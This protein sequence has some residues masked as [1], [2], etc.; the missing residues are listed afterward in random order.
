MLGLRLSEGI[1]YDFFSGSC[2]DRIKE[3]APLLSNA[4]LVTLNDTGIS[5]TTHGFLLSNMVIAAL[6]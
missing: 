5:L 4:G 6:L 2:I 3:K 1:R